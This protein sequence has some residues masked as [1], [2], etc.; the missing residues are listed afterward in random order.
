MYCGKIY[1]IIEN[2]N[3]TVLKNTEHKEHTVQLYN[4]PVK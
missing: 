1:V 2:I 4:K 3:V